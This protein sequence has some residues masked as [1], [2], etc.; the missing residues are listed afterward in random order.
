MRDP[1]TGLSAG[2]DGHAGRSTREGAETWDHLFASI[3]MRMRR[4]LRQPSAG[5]SSRS[6]VRKGREVGGLVSEKRGVS[7]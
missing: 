3:A 4:G 6:D 5:E 2:P 7:A 1:W